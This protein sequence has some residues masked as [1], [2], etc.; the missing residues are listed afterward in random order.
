MTARRY[1]IAV[2]G[3]IGPTLS[4]AFPDFTTDVVGRHH[5]LLVPDDAEDRLISV[6][7]CLDDRGIEVEQV[8]ARYR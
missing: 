6:L 4:S 7:T 8:T 5:V 2:N 1:Q 3:L